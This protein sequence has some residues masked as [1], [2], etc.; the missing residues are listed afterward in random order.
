MYKKHTHHTLKYKGETMSGKIMNLDETIRNLLDEAS[1]AFDKA[2]DARDCNTSVDI[3][4][5]EENTV[6]ATNIMQMAVW[7]MD[8]KQITEN[9]EKG[10]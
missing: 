3:E 10:E 9:A 5:F 8:Y 4:V 6:K 7:L 2:F 1:V